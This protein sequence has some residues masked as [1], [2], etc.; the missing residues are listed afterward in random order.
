MK[1]P[2]AGGPW[3][4][5]PEGELV[6]ALSPVL[7]FKAGAGPYLKPLADPELF[8]LIAYLDRPIF[9]PQ[10]GFTVKSGFQLE[11]STEQRLNTFLE[12]L[13][14]SLYRISGDRLMLVEET[15][16]LVLSSGLSWRIFG[17][18]GPEGPG[19]PPGPGLTLGLNH[20]LRL[21]LS[22]P[23]LTLP[24]ILSNT[25]HAFL[26]IDFINIP[27]EFIIKCLLGSYP[28]YEFDQRIAGNWYR[29]SR[30]WLSIKTIWTFS[31]L[32]TLAL[33]LEILNPEEQAQVRFLVSLG[34]WKIEE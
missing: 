24:D 20:K 6:L 29:G 9:Q 2:Y 31:E 5:Y 32:S 33:G 8:Y 23:G 3:F 16:Q 27:L 12:Y 25:M 28:E 18:K 17:S 19:R 15:E 1:P 7:T 26:K 30:G 14:G 4:L 22:P 13:D 21:A 34:I 10:K 11:L